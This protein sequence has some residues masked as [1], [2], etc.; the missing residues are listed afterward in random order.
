MIEHA[1]PRSITSTSVSSVG[2]VQTYCTTCGRSKFSDIESGQSLS[3][4]E[5]LS[6]NPE[7][8]D[9]A[10]VEFHRTHKPLE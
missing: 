7:A 4:E 2:V 1:H 6:R 3:F 8:W 9:A 5:V 10:A